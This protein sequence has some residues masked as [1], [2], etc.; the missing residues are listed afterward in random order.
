MTTAGLVLAAGEGRRFGSPKAA[1][2]LDGERLVDRAVRI[3]SEAGCAPVFVV[4]GA[5]IGEV[6]TAEVITNREWSKGMGSSL[7]EGLA[8]LQRETDIDRVLISLVD[9]PGL[10]VAA[11]QRVMNSPSQISVAGYGGQRG[12]PVLLHRDHWAGVRQSAQGDKGAR[13][14]LAAHADAITVVDVSDVATG[15][16]LDTLPE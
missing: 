11:V 12:H 14:Y 16:D 9:L 2:V 10:T 15:E 5:W 4:L 13:D 6:P 3:L 8:R 7:Q 1:Y